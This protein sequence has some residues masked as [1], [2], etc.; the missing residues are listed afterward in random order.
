[1]PILDAVTGQQMVDKATGLQMWLTMGDDS[2][3]VSLGTPCPRADV[4][5]ALPATGDGSTATEF[6]NW[7]GSPMSLP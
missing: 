6:V 3:V 7:D 5:L 1:M 4:P 2:G